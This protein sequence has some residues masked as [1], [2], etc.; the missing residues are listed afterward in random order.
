[1]KSIKLVLLVLLITCTGCATGYKREGYGGGYYDQKVGASKYIVGFHGN[2]YTRQSTVREYVFRRAE[3]VCQENGYK[4]FELVSKQD[5]N[6]TE[7]A[8]GQVNC[9]SSLGNTNCQERPG[10]TVTRHGS[11]IVIECTK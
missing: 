10:M 7:R 1:M 9:S 2:G 5:S 3:E 6:S 11:E 4:S 8:P